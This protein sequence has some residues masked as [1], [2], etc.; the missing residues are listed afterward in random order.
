MHSIPSDLIYL[1]EQ[2]LMEHFTQLKFDRYVSDWFPVTNSIRQGDPLSMILYIIY[3]SGLVDVA[4][5]RQGRETLK[6]LTLA[7][8]D[9]TA[10]IAIAKNFEDTHRTL[11]DMLEHPGGG[12]EW[13]RV[14]NSHFETS[15]FALM[16]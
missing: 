12:Y 1:I 10:F 8:I 4:K 16:D 15:K 5:P 3:S 7:F 14:H 11:A 9:D 6:E 13:S 2:V